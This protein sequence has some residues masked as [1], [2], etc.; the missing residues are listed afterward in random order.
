MDVDLRVGLSLSRLVSPL[1]HPSLDGK[2]ER[3]GRGFGF[4]DV[5][6]TYP[7]VVL[8]NPHSL[9]RLVHRRLPPVLGFSPFL[10]RRRIHGLVRFIELPIPL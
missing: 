6:Q 2:P 3:L 9:I 10:P 7:F 4:F 5:L 1:A 8:V